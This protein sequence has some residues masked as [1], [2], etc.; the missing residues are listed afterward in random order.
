MKVL[1]QSDCTHL[2][3]VNSSNSHKLFLLKNLFEVVKLLRLG[4]VEDV[5][6]VDDSP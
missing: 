2:S 3:Y 6:L 4:I 5:L 1:S